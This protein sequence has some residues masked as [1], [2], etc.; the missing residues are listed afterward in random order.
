MRYNFN[1]LSKPELDFL[2]DNCNFTNDES[3]LL[4]MANRE[5]TNIQIAEKLNVTVSTIEKKKKVVYGKIKDF[6]E[7]IEDMTT[8]YV[9]GERVTKEQLKEMEI[10]IESVKRILAEKLTEKK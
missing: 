4:N 1:K 5:Y 3:I 6:M 8:I 7:V 10:R 2:L 9:N